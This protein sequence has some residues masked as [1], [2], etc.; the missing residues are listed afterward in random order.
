MAEVSPHPEFEM[1]QA[2]H[3]V[4][5]SRICQPLRDH[6]QNSSAPDDEWLWC[7]YCERFFQARH[8]RIDDQGNRQGCAF[9]SSAG[10]DCAIH[11]WDTFRDESGGE[12][13]PSS[14]GELSHG[15]SLRSLNPEPIG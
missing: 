4:F 3:S 7:I 5:V 12:V 6:L 9:C 15:L 10:F 14:V 13:W 11:R 8:L 1:M 2:E